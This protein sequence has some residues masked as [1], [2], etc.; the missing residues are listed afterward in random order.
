V[1]QCA[2]PSARERKEEL[3]VW[4][5]ELKERG[6]SQ[7]SAVN[8]LWKDER[9]PTYLTDNHRA[10]FWCWRRHVARDDRYGLAH[11]DWHWDAAS[12]E[13][14]DLQ[15][16]DRSWDSLDDFEFFDQLQSTGRRTFD[17]PARLVRWD[18][19][20]DPFLRLCPGLVEGHLTAHQDQRTMLKGAL[21]AAVEASSAQVYSLEAFFSHID[22]I[23][24]AAAAPMIVNVDLDYFFTDLA[25]QPRRAFDPEFARTFFRVLASHRDKTSV[26]TISLSP[27]CCGGWAPAEELGRFAFDGLGIPWPLPPEASLTN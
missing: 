24:R 20:I 22:G 15:L 25:G 5:R 17:G 14:D 16:L 4:I 26:M 8:V 9:T 7:S 19:Y 10:A 3:V 1:V 6:S 23:L 27:E 13:P 11:V 2:A 12:V 18:N 21:D